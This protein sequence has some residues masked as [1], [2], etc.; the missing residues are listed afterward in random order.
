[1]YCKRIGCGD[2]ELQI[3]YSY[4]YAYEECGNTGKG[5]GLSYM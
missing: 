1:V 4:F 5:I 2:I 3:G